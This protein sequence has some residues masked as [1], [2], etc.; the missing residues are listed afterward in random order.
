MAALEA[1][2]NGTAGAA[3]RANALAF[4]GK[5]HKER[6]D[7]IVVDPPRI[8]LG[9]E[10]TALLSSVAAPEMVYVSCDPATLARDLQKLVSSGYNIESVTLAD[11]FPQTFHLETVVRLRRA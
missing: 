8:G 2:L 6:P 11:L 10:I 9:S 1:N 5:R 3:V 4:L 7:L